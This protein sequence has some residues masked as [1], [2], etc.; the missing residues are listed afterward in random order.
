MNI[1]EY[2]DKQFTLVNSNNPYESV[3]IDAFIKEGCLII[4]NDYFDHGPEGFRSRHV[5]RF[6]KEN[7]RKLFSLLTS[8]NPDPINALERMVNARKN[9]DGLKKECNRANIIYTDSLYL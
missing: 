9:V 1:D 2:E 5:I 4:N 6:D 8:Q 3:F 7:T